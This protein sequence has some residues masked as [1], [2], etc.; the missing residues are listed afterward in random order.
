MIWDDFDPAKLEED[1]QK[2]ILD[3]IHFGGQLIVSG[4]DSLDKLQTSFLANYLPAHFE[5][6]QNLTN[7]DVKELND[8]WAL[9]RRNNPNEKRKLQISEKVPLLG[10]TFKP[11]DDAN[12]I[13]GAGEL[14]IERRVGRGRIA[15]TAFSI[16]SPTIR[17]W[18]SLKSFINGALLRKPP[19][20]FGKLTGEDVGFE[21]AGDGTSCFDPM[22]NSTL[23][24][25]SRDLSVSGTSNKPNIHFD[26][27]MGGGMGINSQYVDFN[28]GDEVLLKPRDTV[29]S[30]NR[31]IRRLDDNFHYGGFQEDEYAGLGGWND[32]SGIA[33][34][35]RDT[36]KETAGITP[37]SSSF[38]LKMLAA[39]LLILVPVNWVLFRMIGKVEYAWAAA[40][41]IAIVG[42]FMVVRM[43][44]LDI[45]FVRSNT[46]VGLLEVHSDYSRGHLSEYSALYTSLSTGYSV[47]LD[48][49]SA[50]SLPFAIV[51]NS[52]AF[53]PDES[54]SEVK[55]RR[56][57]SNRLEGF[58]IQSNSTGLLH[59][60]I[61]LNLGGIVS[62]S[63]PKDGN[64]AYLAN[65]TG[66]DLSNVGVLTKNSEGKFEF[67]WIGDL[68]S[69]GEADVI[70]E[71]A[72]NEQLNEKWARLPEFQSTQR[73]AESIWNTNITNGKQATMEMLAAIPELQEEWPRYESLFT[74]VMMDRG[75]DMIEPGQFFNIYQLVNSSSQV[76]LGQMLDVV[77]N[78][79]KLS[80]G[81]YRLIGSTEQRLGTSRFDPASTQTDRR[82]LVIVHLKHPKLPKAER[83]LN[84]YEDF[85]IVSDLDRKREME[86][87]E[88]AAQE[89]LPGGN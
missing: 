32:E 59:S 26:T 63:P 34:A 54:M 27:G 38:V 2:A 11:H 28:P 86:E 83:D 6:S 16:N 87:L 65:S 52:E 10:V 21:W 37:P 75:T 60:E 88:K 9:P 46:Q 77:L 14:V 39:Y 85:K 45:G 22:I 73:N 41:I 71:P 15:I 40:P 3:W 68:N 66:I 7:A 48:N 72:D 13:D 19:R 18:R 79:L 43:A 23:R 51:N 55:L 81:E 47:D 30:T 1:H 35:A 76:T 53:S 57:T 5:S 31:G 12:F 89:S 69:A 29:N 44:S 61:M 84:A 78:N 36:L 24:F 82:T 42:A 62:F 80:E 64:P 70:F 17:S 67:G 4:P 58:Q 33:I 49:L 20:N 50:Q 8:N 56:T 74:K 25:V